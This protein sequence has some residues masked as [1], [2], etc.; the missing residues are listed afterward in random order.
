MLVLLRIDWV[1]LVLRE[2]EGVSWGYY[3]KAAVMSKDWGSILI[4]C[5]KWVDACSWSTL[6]I[7][8][9]HI[10]RLPAH[11]KTL[12]GKGPEH[13]NIEGS[14]RLKSSR[15]NVLQLYMYGSLLMKSKVSSSR[16]SRTSDIALNQ[17]RS[18]FVVYKRIDLK[19]N[20]ELVTVSPTLWNV[21]CEVW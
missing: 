21:K 1:V 2:L 6:F 13:R 19:L 4:A 17:Q 9:P 16:E 8:A 5:I 12:P 18:G 3:R 7:H 10:H 14:M 20:S 11:K 15:L